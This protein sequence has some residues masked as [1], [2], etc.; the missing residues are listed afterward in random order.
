MQR[1]ALV[2]GLAIQTSMLGA[3]HALANHPT[4][5]LEVTHGHAV[6]LMLPHVIRFNAQNAPL[7][8]EWY[9]EL[10]RD[11]AH[12]E[13]GESVAVADQPALSLAKYVESLAASVGLG[14]ELAS[15]GVTAEDVA[16]LAIDATKQWTGSF[17][18]CAL[19]END[20]KQLYLNALGSTQ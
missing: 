2:G 15:Y 1:G 16:R 13:L 4:A 20:F 5:L 18:R 8:A 12:T 3:A 11:I 14:S 17:N 6:G 10:W 9:T 7:A 19:Q